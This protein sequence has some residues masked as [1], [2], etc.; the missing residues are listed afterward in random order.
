MKMLLVEDN[1]GDARLLIELLRESRLEGHEVEAVT[2][3]SAARR[4]L[5]SRNFDVV[6]LDLS[7]PDS[8]GL[9]T[10]RAGL[11]AAGDAAIVVLTGLDDDAIALRAVN[12]GAQDYLAKGELDGRLLVRA[13]RHARERKRL[14]AERVSALEREQEARAAV[15]AALRARDEVLRIVSHDLGNSLSAVGIQAKLLERDTDD[16]EVQRRARAIRS[17][18]E[19]MHRLRQDLLDVVSL[20]AGSLAMDPAPHAVESILAEAV[21]AVEE[22]PA[23]RKLSIRVVTDDALPAI[24]VDR[25]RILQVMGNLLGNSVKFTPEGGE[26]V[27][28]AE[29]AGNEVVIS[30]E[31]NGPG[32]P[33]ED[34]PRIFDPFWRKENHDRVGAG[35]GLAIAKGIITRHGGRIWVETVPGCGSAFRFTVPMARPRNGNSG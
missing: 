5:E 12:A 20:E 34:V 21:A 8:Q 29:Q 22:L 14:E 16:A 19:Q 24:E 1:P 30:V 7:L 33:A 28:R 32:I 3:L 13:I 4:A 27:V 15:E 23:A 18:V 6:L 35:L 17:L 9:D 2:T 10:V 31:D 11:A 25:I 26:V